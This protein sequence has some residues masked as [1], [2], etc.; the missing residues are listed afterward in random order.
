MWFHGRFT[1]DA[2]VVV[3]EHG[4]CVWLASQATSSNWASG[5]GEKNLWQKFIPFV[6][7]V[8]KLYNRQEHSWKMGNNNLSLRRWRDGVPWLVVTGPCCQCHQHRHVAAHRWIY[9]LKLAHHKPKIGPKT[10]SHQRKFNGSYRRYRVWDIRRNEETFFQQPDNACPH[11]CLRTQEAITNFCSTVLCYLPYAPDLTPSY[12]HI[13]WPLEDA[14]CPPIFENNHS[15]IR[16]VRTWL[17][18]Q[19]ANWYKRDMHGLVP[20]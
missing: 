19:E 8:W 5:G 10:F 14:P 13:F 9:L 6:G 3:C 15:I 12:F 7:C 11:N 16:A 2:V 17:H 20:H 18:E 1:E 4:V